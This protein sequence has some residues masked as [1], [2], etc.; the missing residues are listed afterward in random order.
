VSAPT[1]L[2]GADTDAQKYHE[3][4]VAE[5]SHEPFSDCW[6]CC[7]DC[8]PSS[9]GANPNPYWPAARAQIDHRAARAVR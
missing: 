4:A 8:D 1:P 2:A 6:C 9:G 3:Q 5:G 7:W